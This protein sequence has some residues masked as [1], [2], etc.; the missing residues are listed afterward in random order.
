[1]KMTIASIMVA[2][3][4]WASAADAAVI[5]QLDSSQGSKSDVVRVWENTFGLS[6]KES[7]KTGQ[8]QTFNPK[9]QLNPGLMVLTVNSAET[10]LKLQ[11]YT[12]YRPDISI[13]NPTGSCVTDISTWT[14]VVGID[15]DVAATLTQSNFRLQNGFDGYCYFE[16]TFPAPSGA[17]KIPPGLW[18]AVARINVAN[19]VARTLSISACTPAQ[20][21]Q[22]M[23]RARL[24]Q[25][26][27]NFYTVSPSQRDIALG[28]GYQNRG[29]PFSMPSFSGSGSSIAF[30]RYYKGAPQYEHFYSTNTNDVSYLLANGYVAEGIEGYVFKGAKP[31]AV[32]LMRYALFNGAN[33]DLQHYYTITPN[34]PEAAGWGYDGVVGYVC[35]P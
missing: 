4:L 18:S 32:A 12:G 34:D 1:M 15:N 22:P 27:D 35:P 3:A 16:A 14:I 13:Y 11:W 2:S 31:G 19:P 24:A 33:G 30:S 20:G 28:I 5:V 25:Y 29:I 23:Y 8:Q 6:S 10:Q 9:A 7:F 17:A 26:T 21:K